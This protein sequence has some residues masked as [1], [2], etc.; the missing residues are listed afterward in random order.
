MNFDWTNG[1]VP[2][3]NFTSTTT[4]KLDILT[5]TST[6]VSSFASYSLASLTSTMATTLLSSADVASWIGS[7]LSTT[8]SPTP[9]PVSSAKRLDDFRDYFVLVL[10]FLTA[11]IGMF[12]N[13]FVCW[14][15]WKNPKLRSTTYY[16]LFNMAISDFL[17]GFVIL[18]QWLFCQHHLLEWF[19]H[20]H[21]V[22]GLAKILQV[23][24][25]Y[26]STY[27]MLFVA[28]DRYLL[29]CHPATRGLHQKWIPIA[30]SWLAGILFSSTAW[31]SLRVFTYFG[32]NSLVDC[33][34]VFKFIKMTR[35]L[36]QLRL[37]V[38]LMAQFVVPFLAIAILYYLVWRTIRERDVVG[39]R[40]E[41]NVKKVSEGK[42]KLIKMLVIV[43]AGFGLAWLPL[44]VI[45]LIGFYVFPIIPNT[46]RTSTYYGFV[47]WLGISSCCYNPFIYYWGNLE[48][49]NEFA[50]IHAKL[51]GKCYDYGG[52]CFN[53]NTI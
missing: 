15:I 46:C 12:G 51:T 52:K 6:D 19:D 49:R 1:Y 13:W 17:A 44:H 48:F 14:V 8:A 25:Y 20:F 16:L 42:Q 30:L 33:R 47:Y 11:M 27:S 31:T 36:N 24:S 37:L 39:A 53:L 38:M 4:T 43:V 5:R 40:T 28:I 22:C 50:A 34:L 10:Y 32:P 3:H 21:S 35:N 41:S 45:H 26:L 23:I 2:I 9:A 7:S 29:V 18:A